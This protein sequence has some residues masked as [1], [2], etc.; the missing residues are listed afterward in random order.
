MSPFIL[1]PCL[2]DILTLFLPVLHSC[3]LSSIWMCVFMCQNMCSLESWLN[4]PLCLK[5]DCF[6]PYGP[7]CLA[8]EL[9]KILLFLSIHC[10]SAGVTGVGTC[11]NFCLGSR[12][13]N[14]GTKNWVASTFPKKT[15]RKYHWRKNFNVR[16]L[17]SFKPSLGY[18]WIWMELKLKCFKDL[19]F[20]FL[21]FLSCKV[22][23][24]F[25]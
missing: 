1:H 17:H 3:M 2:S 24:T 11:A 10:E 20:F 8:W 13:L 4:F 6:L 12:N 7:F 5:Q 9:L 16:F 14:S 19:K 22:F 18:F 23:Q 25:R 21:K 15:S